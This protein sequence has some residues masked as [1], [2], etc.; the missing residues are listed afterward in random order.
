MKFVWRILGLL[1]GAV[2]VFAGVTKIIDFQP[3]RFLDPMDFARD[4]DNY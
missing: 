3:V 4:I 1:V 2:F